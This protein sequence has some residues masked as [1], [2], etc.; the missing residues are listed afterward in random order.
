MGKIGI[1]RVRG[2]WGKSPKVSE[3]FR[4]LRLERVNRCAVYEDTPSLRGMLDAIKDYATWG[5]VDSK[6][7]GLLVSK[8]GMSG[9]SRFSKAAAA[10]KLDAKAVAAE[11][12]EGKKK[13]ADYGITPYF[14]LTP[15]SG[16][17]GTI[18]YKYPKGA[19]GK[20]DAAEFAA[21]VKSMC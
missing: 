7:F 15:P 16:G 14:K 10:K 11:I 9:N 19:L 2:L 18:K 13:Y 21:L 8:R 17:Y 6:T 5:E 1:I 4:L 20:R 3:T 12:F